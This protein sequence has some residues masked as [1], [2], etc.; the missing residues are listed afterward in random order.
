MKALGALLLTAA[1]GLGGLSGARRLARREKML[2]ELAFALE[3]LGFELAGFRPPMPELAARLAV[4]APGAGGELFGRLTE[5][6]EALPE[7]SFAALWA[8]AL[9]EIAGPERE[10][11]LALGGV[12]GRY[13]AEDQR[14][15]AEGCRARLQALEAEAKEA[16]R[17]SGK[18]YVGLGLAAGAMA[19]V[20]LL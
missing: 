20:M 1:F 9:G 14:I 18:L 5:V 2:G 10:A 17:R 19:S 11:L 12:L 8:R 15:A 4:L 6:L 3:L 7:E 16:Y 13:G